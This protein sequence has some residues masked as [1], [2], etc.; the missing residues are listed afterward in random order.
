[1]VQKL[2][3]SR[4]ASSPTLDWSEF[5]NAF[6]ER[7]MPKSLCDA[8]AREFE[9]LKQTEGMS[10]LDY[11]TKFNQLARYAPH[12]VMT[13]NM[14]AKRFANGLKE[15]LFRAIPLTRT[16][17]YSDVLDTALRFEARTKERQVEQEPRKK[18][19]T[20]E[21]VFRQS[22]ATGSGTAAGTNTT[23]PSQGNQARLVTQSVGNTGRSG[24]PYCQTCRYSHYGRCG[25]AGACFKCGQQG[26]MKRDCPLNV[27]QP[28]YGATAS[29]S[30]VAPAYS[31]GSVAQPLGRG[32]TSRGAQSDMRGQ[33]VGGRGQARAFVLNPRDAHATNEIVTGIL[34]ICS[35]QAVVLIDSDATHCFVSL[36]FAWCLVI[37]FDVLSSSLTVL[38]PVREVVN[39]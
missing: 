19:K 37:R 31:I 23:A 17:T 16:S 3:R 21:Q 4:L 1:M 28:M 34:T 35:R 29:P 33:T 7:F 24:A 11:D 8:K 27:S 13:D 10:V 22:E 2:L 32:T 5:Y 26:H 14:K 9:L 6:V 38:T 15:Y 20:G 25:R 39:K 30:V 36:S 12:M 18:A